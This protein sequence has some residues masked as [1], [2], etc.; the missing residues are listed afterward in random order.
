MKT[1]LLDLSHISW[2]ISG[3]GVRQWSAVDIALRTPHKGFAQGLM[4][5]DRVIYIFQTQNQL[6]DAI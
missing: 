6:R 3:A 4:H 1:M 2:Q 5:L